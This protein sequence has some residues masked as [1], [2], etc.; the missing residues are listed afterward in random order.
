MVEFREFPTLPFLSATSTISSASCNLKGW[1]LVHG[2]PWPNPALTQNFSPNGL[3]VLEIWQ[4]MLF[5]PNFEKEGK[6]E[7]REKWQLWQKWQ[8]AA[9]ATGTSDLENEKKRATTIKITILIKVY[10]KVSFFKKVILQNQNIFDIWYP[11]S[12]M[13]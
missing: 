11:I 6:M 10:E 13:R 5:F 3:V 8:P 2:T 1:N 9:Q 4:N 12:N 7:R